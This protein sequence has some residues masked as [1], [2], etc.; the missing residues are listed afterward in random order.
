MTEETSV[1]L[2]NTVRLKVSFYNFAKVLTDVTAGPTLKIYGLRDPPLETI[3][4]GIQHP[5]TGVYYYDYVTSKEGEFIYEF[6]GTVEDT[7]SVAHG[8]LSV[9]FNL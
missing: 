4:E 5:S 8:K 2:G 7:P 3:T 6:S 1:L 9:I